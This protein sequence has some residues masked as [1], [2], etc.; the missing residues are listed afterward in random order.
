MTTLL[1]L[2][3]PEGKVWIDGVDVTQIGLTDLR[4]IMSVIPQVSQAK[5][6]EYLLKEIL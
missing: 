3:Q 5:S 2:V 4:Q 6:M 1:R